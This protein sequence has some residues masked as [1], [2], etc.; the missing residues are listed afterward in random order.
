MTSDLPALPRIPGETKD[1]PY[2][3]PG[4]SIVSVLTDEHVQL[5]TLSADLAHAVEPTRAQADVFTAAVT[6]HLTAERQ[7]LH[8]TVARTFGAQ[9][10][11][12]V[13]R[14]H[15]RDKTL[16]NGLASLAKLQPGSEGFG[17]L[18]VAIDA[19]LQRHV[20]TCKA[21]IFPQLVQAATVTDLVRLGNRVEIVKETAPSRPHPDAPM[22][23]P[24]N[25]ITDPA[26][27]TVDSVR[28]LVTGR[29]TYPADP[30]A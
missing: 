13:D 6:R 28:D 2:V 21:E 9:G 18:A 16:L 19:D 24:L 27:G 8:P 5:M 3:P 20:S 7:L 15:R 25:R 23:Q 1:R 30:A 14:E 10:A 22:R 29:E 26:L 12:I 4:R 17:H 11:G